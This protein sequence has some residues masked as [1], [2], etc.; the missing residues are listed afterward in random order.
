MTKSILTAK[1][2]LAS[3][4]LHM[5][6]AKRIVSANVDEGRLLLDERTLQELKDLALSLGNDVAV[7]ESK[8]GE[9]GRITFGSKRFAIQKSE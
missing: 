5:K 3:A 8:L 4:I 6:I 7:I 9:Y 1:S 2:E